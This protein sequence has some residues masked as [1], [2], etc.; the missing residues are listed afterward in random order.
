MKLSDKEREIFNHLA[1]E[2]QNLSNALK[3]A[4]QLSEKGHFLVSTS[5][6]SAIILSDRISV[7]LELFSTYLSI[8]SK[9]KQWR[10]ENAINVRK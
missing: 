4:S 1:K 6:D 5:I 3:D 8:K 2:A 9:D 7:R 10:L